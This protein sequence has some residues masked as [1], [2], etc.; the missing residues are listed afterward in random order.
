MSVIN[1]NSIRQG[2]RRAM[3]K[4]ITLV[5]STH[6]EKLD[7]GQT[8]LEELLPDTGKSLRIGITGVPGVGKSTFIEAF[9][10]RLIEAGH[11][12]AVLAVDPSSPITGGSILGDKT[13]MQQLSSHPQAFVRPSPSSGVLGGVARNTREIMLLCEA[14]GYDVIIVETVGVGQSETMVASMADLFLVLMLPNAGDE[15]QGIKKGILELADLIVIN[16]A[17]GDQKTL[18]QRAVREYRNALQLLKPTRASWKAKVLQCSALEQTGLVE[19]WEVMQDFREMLKTS[20]EWEEHR[21]HQAVRWMWSLIDEELRQS[22]RKH[23][24][25][26]ADIPRVEKAIRQG[27]Q[28]PTR[29]ARSL[30]DVWFSSKIPG[31]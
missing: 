19:L 24:Q 1:P 11:Q 29:A 7:Q 14:A 13:R 31:K 15:L 23:S 21:S 5:E 30:L 8:L 18:A 12:V 17:D 27:K 26:Q 2:D 6:P 3:A 28:L 22:F 10:M 20:G 9:G 16:K 25:I 4:A